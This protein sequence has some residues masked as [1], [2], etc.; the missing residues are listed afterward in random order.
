MHS[1]SGI[2]DIGQ[3]SPS[4]NWERERG[5]D[6]LMMMGLFQLWSL[7]TKTDIPS[8]CEVLIN[9]SE[10]YVLPLQTPAIYAALYVLKAFQILIWSIWWITNPIVLFKFV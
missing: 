3:K 5:G 9:I 7:W 10:A 1:E 6:W 2:E 4:A 8:F